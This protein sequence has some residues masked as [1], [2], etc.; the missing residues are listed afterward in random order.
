MSGNA[1]STRGRATG[2]RLPRRDWLK[3]AAITCFG[4]RAMAAPAVDW[5]AKAKQKLRLGVYSGVYSKLR[6]E[7]AVARIRDDGFRSVLSNYTFADV[8][9][10]PL[11][12]DW[13]AAGKI[14]GCFERHGIEIVA[15]F[16]YV[17]LVD[18]IPARRKQGDVRLETL[19]TNWKRL[20][21]RNVST[22]T[23]TFNPKS[24]WLDAPKNETEEGYL[25]CRAAI[26]KWAKVAEKAGAVLSIE[27]YWRNV[28]GSIDRADRLFREVQSPALKLVMDPNNYFRK[29]ELPKMQPMLEEMFRRLGPHIVLAHAKDVKPA[30]EGTEL[31]ASGKGVLDY[32]LF[33]RL[34]AQLD[35]PLDLIVEHLTLD[36]VPRARDFVLEQFDKI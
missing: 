11:A 14:V 8:R 31:P 27:A 19:L 33:L 2:K 35:R 26:E 32:P 24:A 29:E 23:G 5:R 7:E 13:E 25:Q 12:P 30:A 18:P 17:N 3:A 22:E 21:C 28:I 4:A 10:D 16:G 20:G 34:L 36:D 9:F 6:L 15:V 1:S